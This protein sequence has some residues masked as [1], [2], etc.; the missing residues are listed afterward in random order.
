[1]FDLFFMNIYELQI[2]K[3]EWDTPEIFYIKGDNVSRFGINKGLEEVSL[4][5]TYS[6]NFWGKGGEI[7]LN[8]INGKKIS[9]KNIY[10]LEIKKQ[11]ID[12]SDVI[13]LSSG[14]LFGKMKEGKLDGLSSIK[15]IAWSFS[16]GGKAYFSKLEGASYD[17][18]KRMSDNL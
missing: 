2:R 15:T 1:M 6:W 12:N 3:P 9:S 14:K 4:Y 18:V 13:Y 16:K 5:G 7:F 8:K 11:G 17:K 10:K